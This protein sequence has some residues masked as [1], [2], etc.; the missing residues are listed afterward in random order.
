MLARQQGRSWFQETFPHEKVHQTLREYA[1]ANPSP[2]AG[3]LILQVFAAG[4]NLHSS[5]YLLRIP[6]VCSS[7]RGYCKTSA[8][9]S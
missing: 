3:D 9:L 6:A 7:L 2:D 8:A 4:M 1:V 5:L